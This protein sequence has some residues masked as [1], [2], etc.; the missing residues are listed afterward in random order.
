M[1]PLTP[2]MFT[3]H[4][5]DDNEMP[6]TDLATMAC[7]AAIEL[8]NTIL[9]RGQRL[10]TVKRLADQMSYLVARIKPTSPTSFTDPTAV[11]L[12]KR[13]VEDFAIGKAHPSTVDELAEIAST[14]QQSLRELLKEQQ[15][16]KDHLQKMRSFCLALSESASSY[17]HSIDELRQPH[18]YWSE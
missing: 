14:I 12:M 15:P 11:V 16:S 4:Q 8:D 3:V 2:S 10:E 1:H 9:G 7:R 17:Q 6:T 18:S 13:A 5:V